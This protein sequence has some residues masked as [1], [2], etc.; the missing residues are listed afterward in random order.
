MLKYSGH[1]WLF[2]HNTQNTAQHHPLIC[3]NLILNL[4]IPRRPRPPPAAG[5]CRR[6]RRGPSRTAP[7]SPASGQ[8]MFETEH[9]LL[10]QG[11]PSVRGKP[12][13]DLVPA[14]LAAGG[15]LL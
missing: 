4:I 5:R 8:N 7:A 3:L 11:G 13:V 15:P 6:R 10:L 1:Q 9:L 14:L 2:I 12:I